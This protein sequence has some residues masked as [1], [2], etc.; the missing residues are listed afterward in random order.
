MTRAQLDAKI[1][2][3]SERAFTFR[4]IGCREL[5]SDLVHRVEA[6]GHRPEVKLLHLHLYEKEYE[7]VRSAF[8]STRSAQQD[9]S[10][11]SPFC[12]KVPVLSLSKYSIL[13]SSSGRVLVLTMVPGISGSFWIWRA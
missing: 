2:R 3:R 5:M 11:D 1:G 7:P 4:S 9:A 13:P 12:V 6:V 10:Q 8:F